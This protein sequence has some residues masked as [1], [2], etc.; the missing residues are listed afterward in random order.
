MQKSALAKVLITVITLLFPIL[1]FGTKTDSLLASIK[2]NFSDSEKVVIYSKIIQQLKADQ[3]PEIIKYFKQGEYL[4]I[5]STKKHV[6]TNFYVYNALYITNKLNAFNTLLEIINTSIDSLSK[7]K[8]YHALSEAHNIKA[9]HI[10]EPL[11]MQEECHTALLKS[12]EYSIY[13]DSLFHSNRLYVLGWN[14]CTHGMPELGLKHLQSALVYFGNKNSDNHRFELMNWIGN[15]YNRLKDYPKALSWLL[16]SAAL[17]DKAGVDYFKY[18]SYRY[19]SQSY[20][21]I[22]KL[23]SAIYYTT[24]TCDYLIKEKI[25]QRVPYILSELLRYHVKAGKLKE[26]EVYIKLL[27]DTTSFNYKSNLETRS[28]TGK[29]LFNYYLAKKDYKTAFNY[30]YDYTATADTMHAKVKRLNVGGQDLKYEF[31][32]QQEQQKLEQQK[33]DFEARDKLRRQRLFNYAM[34]G[35]VIVIC[36]LLFMAYKIIKQK[37]NAFKEISLQKQ[38]VE[39]QKSIVDIK[40]KE[41]HDSITYAKRLQEAILPDNTYLKSHFTDAFLYYVPKDIVAGDFY[42]FDKTESHII[43]AAADCTGHGV[44]GALVSVVCSNALNRSINEFNLREPGEILDKTRELVVK[45]F[46]KSQNN[47]RD[48]MD[49]SLISIKTKKATVAGEEKVEIQWSGANN[50]L[51]YIQNNN[52]T[53]IKGHKQPIGKADEY[54]SFPTH[55][56][57]LTKGD[58]LYLITDGYADQFG[59]PKGKKFKYK[60]LSD[61]ILSSQTKS[62][63]NQQNELDTTFTNWKGNL[64]QVDDV[65]IIGIRI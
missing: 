17:S 54:S 42:F 44:P 38:E 23:D 13:V 20:A 31:Q 51:W 29:T 33:K 11:D 58:T 41:I 57:T 53:E 32:K 61:L 19:A 8:E 35:V 37:Q 14:E 30:L 43:L 4:A 27:T 52:F 46:D 64:E 39:N 26:A 7:T 45:L 40:N 5:K 56:I 12:S 60:P 2:P 48:G 63:T 47:V 15:A 36:I 59:G 65:C 49:I 10:F 22:N 24:L 3:K 6:L 28:I 55:T 34:I 9:R 25:Y 21:A 50:P 1:S 62:M 18:D 16:R